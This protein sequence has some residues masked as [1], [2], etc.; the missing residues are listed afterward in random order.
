MKAARKDIA[1]T[2][3]LAMEKLALAVQDRPDAAFIHRIAGLKPKVDKLKKQHGKLKMTV[4]ELK[5]SKDARDT[6]VESAAHGL[7][8][9]DEKAQQDVES[10][11][12]TQQKGII[13]LQ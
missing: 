9:G 5:V 1:M 8:W 6:P 3:Q 13:N 11:V 10:H 7:G 2:M 4:E 12:H